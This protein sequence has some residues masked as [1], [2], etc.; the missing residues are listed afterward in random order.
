MLS[1]SAKKN[2]VR[3]NRNRLGDRTPKKARLTRGFCKYGRV[4]SNPGTSTACNGWQVFVVP[5][6]GDANNNW[7]V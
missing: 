3:I 7:I 1:N 5:I 2:I 4:K 6:K